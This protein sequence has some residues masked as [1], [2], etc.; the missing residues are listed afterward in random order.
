MIQLDF[1]IPTPYRF[2]FT[3]IKVIFLS[4]CFVACS[5]SAS[6]E[7]VEITQVEPSDFADTSDVSI[8]L[9]DNFTIS[10]WAPGKLL[11]S[12][13]SLTFDNQGNA[14]VSETERRKSSDIDIR[15]H[16]D[17]VKEDLQLTSLEE[18]EAFH[19]RKLAPELSDQNTWLED[20]N[21]DGSHDW[22]DLTVQSER[23]RK[24]WDSDG[25]GA[26]DKSNIFA[27]DFR[28]MLTGVA[29][30]ITYH[31]GDVFLTAAPDLWRIQDT[32]DNGRMDKKVSVSHGYGIHIGYAGHDMSGLT[33]GP[34]GKLY[35]SI[36]DLG[37]NTVDQ[38]GKQWKYP[39]HGAIMRANPDGSEFEVYAY[40]LRNPQEIAFDK[41]GN[42]ITVDNDGDH[43]GEHE[44]IIH[45]I[46]GSDSGW[47]T[48]WQFGKY[49][50]PGGAYKVWMDE[51]LHVPYFEGQAAYI[52]PPIALAQDGPA[53]LA[54]NPGTAL[55]KQWEDHFFASYFSGSSAQSKIHAF[56]LQP[57]G[58]TFTVER[59]VEVL[60]GINMT[61]VSFG[62]DGA[63]YI[64]DWLDTYD[65]K[66][67]GRIWRL[68]TEASSYDTKRE[69]VKAL[70][71]TGMKNLSGKE[72]TQL[73][74]HED[75]RVRMD[76]QFELVDRKDTL[77][78]LVA[79]RQSDPLLARIHGIWGMGQLARAHTDFADVLL[80]LLADPTD[81]VRAQTAKVLGDAQYKSAVPFLL[82]QITDSNPRAQFFAV[83]ALGKLN[84]QQAFDP[85]VDLLAQVGN[86]DTHLRYSIFVAW[87][88]LGDV[89]KLTQLSTHDNESV[90]LG[91]VVALRR[92]QSPEVERFLAD[93]DS[94]V[95]LEAARAIHDDESIETALPTLAAQLPDPA[96]SS[97][98][99]VRRVINANLRIGD[100]ESA[101]RLAAFADRAD[102]ADSFRVVALE[103]LGFWADPPE[104]DWVVGQYREAPSLEPQI[105]HNA[106]EDYKE[107]WLLQ[108]P[109]QVRVATANM[110]GKLKDTQSES[111]LYHLAL[112]P[113]HPPTVRAASLMALK[114]MDS[115]QTVDAMQQLLGDQEMQ[116][117]QVALSMASSMELPEP[118]VVDMM[119]TVLDHGA[120]TEQQQALANL[121]SLS[122]KE[123]E[124][125]LAEW[126]DKLA[127]GKVAPELQLDVWLAIENSSFETLKSQ[128]EELQ[129][130]LNEQS[131]LATYQ[132]A[133]YGGN[134][135][136]GANIFYKNNSA[137]CIRC[138]Q[139]D[140]M[141]GM[142]GPELT[143]IGA[144][145]SPQQ[146]IASLVAPSDRI[147][148]G[149]G[150]V[151]L[152]LE[153][154]ETMTGTLVGENEQK[155]ILQKA[156][157]ENH[158]IPVSTIKTRKNA[159]S[160]MPSMKPL[161]T[162]H[163]I[164]D[165]M[166]YLMTLDDESQLS[167]KQE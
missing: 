68:D 11:S 142:V 80:P 2:Y 49:N 94:L 114:A 143:G 154:G 139:I 125:V 32:D 137:Q 72:L 37:V 76:A 74:S 48:Y 148:P 104:F 108:A 149:Y 41:W 64:A 38:T 33:V 27:E 128:Q 167:M 57:S 115:N 55:S 26:A 28:T 97:E 82:G 14:Y 145:L 163:E 30:G 135:R 118:T 12:P 129:A 86:S 61:G 45:V 153:D 165:V 9:K 126:L 44:R 21:Q 3:S 138:H 20:F 162:K 83:E 121:A 1:Y 124:A 127:S 7:V 119:Q 96:V 109:T 73:L 161:L 13:V 111:T 152:T 112:S 65:K 67:I 51:R 42:L 63:L 29:A 47:R 40:G 131:S 122:A 31:Q 15:V 18:T 151:T 159:P 8:Q 155:I 120:V 157:G 106:I 59:D 75:M 130:Q 22:R 133:M 84:A 60:K 90:R 146:L 23:I 50:Q 144:K 93:S 4:L 36:G 81:E 43:A 140:K 107:D 79:T 85:L 160:A 116:V 164:R 46:E 78:L 5:K 69:E 123:A 16:R 77:N 136:T 102:A 34:D 166:A 71:A 105:A 25:D 10:L 24:V 88:R 117:R 66:P 62:P 39:H 113:S 134:P 98:A 147:A 56:K 99:F 95:A 92:L 70:L 87:A 101:N 52:L 110:L 156:S 132:M 141:G 58:A 103:A 100:Q 35:W 17:W 54:Y 158:E 150:I 89:E 19:K 53:G 6:D 91:A